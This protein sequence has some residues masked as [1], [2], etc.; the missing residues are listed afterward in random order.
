MFVCLLFYWRDFAKKRNLRN[1]KIEKE[2]ILELF[3]RL[4]VR[5]QK[6][7][8]RQIHTLGFY[9]VAKNIDG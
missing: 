8:N 5:K 2:L 3:S 9:F 4:K 6:G 7:K 1:K